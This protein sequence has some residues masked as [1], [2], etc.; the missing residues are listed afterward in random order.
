MLATVANTTTYS[1]DLPDDY[2]TPVFSEDKYV[3][4]INDGT[5]ISMF[6]L[7]NPNQRIVDDA[8]FH[9]N[10]ATFV[11][12]KIVL[13]RAPKDH[14]LGCEIVLDVVKY[15]PKLTRDNADAIDLLY[16]KQLA[17]LGVAKNATL[18]DV[19]KVNLNP[20]FTQKYTNELQK[21]IAANNASNEIDEMRRTSYSYI[22]GLW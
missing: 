11:D 19:P 22:G 14:E 12:R 18:A 1:F 17:V 9:H 6:K 16:S 5:V 20:V 10:R 8:D 2:R 15:M 21:A 4:F 13:S 3:K 7:V